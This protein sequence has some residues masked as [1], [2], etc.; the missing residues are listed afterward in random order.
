VSRRCA[1]CRRTHRDVRVVILSERAG[2]LVGAMKEHAK[3]AHRSNASSD[4]VRR[5]GVFTDYASR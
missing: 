1:H 5:A 3:G 2:R 4:W